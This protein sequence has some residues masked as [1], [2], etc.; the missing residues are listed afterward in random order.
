M[1]KVVFFHGNCSDGLA[2]AYC[3]Y[4]SKQ[5]DTLFYPLFHDTMNVFVESLSFSQIHECFF[6]DIVPSFK[7]LDTIMKNHKNHLRIV[8]IDHHVTN[9]WV[10]T[11]FEN[12]LSVS[13]WF[14]ISRSACALSYIWNNCADP[15]L[16]L[17][18]VED[19]DLFKWTVPNSKAFTEMYYN[20]ESI[21]PPSSFNNN[22][23]QENIIEKFKNMKKYEND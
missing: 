20:D 4:N 17:L 1:N 7:T 12:D 3:F 18:H 10:K 21:R 19:R 11:E 15:P 5:N 22:I 2:A 6:L 16:F 8:I 9:S 23:T 13:V 14:D